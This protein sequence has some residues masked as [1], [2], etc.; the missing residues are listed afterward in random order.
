[1]VLYVQSDAIHDV[2]VEAGAGAVSASGNA[3]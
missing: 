1:M 2:N 3:R